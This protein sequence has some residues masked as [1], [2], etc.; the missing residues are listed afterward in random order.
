MKYTHG[1][2]P[3]IR[4]PVR[5]KSDRLRGAE[6]GPADPYSSRPAE[7]RKWLTTFAAPL[8]G[9]RAAVLRTFAD[10]PAEV[11]YLYETDAKVV[12]RATQPHR[13]IR[14]ELSQLDPESTRAVVTCMRD[15]DVDRLTASR[16][17]R[18]MEQILEPADIDIRA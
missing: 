4:P 15:S 17:I 3:S 14:I 12:I 18:A 10:M 13:Q 9:V 8:S 2:A 6:H 5:L 11:A 16:I 7:S 1:S